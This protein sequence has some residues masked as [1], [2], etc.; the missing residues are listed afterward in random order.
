MRIGIW[1]AYGKTLEPTEGIGVFAHNLARGLVEIDAVERVEL[2]VHAGDEPLVADSVS[3]GGGRVGT[4]SLQ[5][6]RLIERWRWK[7]LRRRHRR[8]SDR[9]AAN[10]RRIQWPSRGRDESRRLAIERAIRGIFAAQRVSEPDAFDAC[11]VWLLPHV[12]VERPFRTASVVVVHDMV[13][14]HFEG[15]VKRSDLA[16]FR[17][18]SCRA[19]EDATLVATMSHTIRDV[20]VVGLLGCDPAKVRVVPPATPV[21]SLETAA[22]P[23]SP[24]VRAATARPFLLYPAA[25]RPY[26]NHATLVAALA[27][28]SRRGRT[29]LGLVFTGGGPMPPEIGSLVSGLGLRGRVH[30]L[31]TVPRGTLSSLYTRAAATIVPSLYEQ[32]SFPI[33]EAIQ[34]GCPAAASD[35]ASLRESLAPLGEAM[36]YFEPRSAESIADAVERILDDREAVRAGQA[37]AFV[38]MRLRSWRDVAREW[39][40]VFEE[41]IAACGGRSGPK[42]A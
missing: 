7:R 32:G 33:L 36:I 10:G 6:L 17:R 29:D 15:V 28:L 34:R 22:E 8:L 37:D 27:E 13:P 11:D 24:A 20:D 1:C 38:V 25:F 14:L 41:A 40:A 21:E 3:G 19:V 18:R 23:P 42:G 35:L 30:P 2:L 39:V 9:L 5:R 4:I 31:G 16:S 26:K 12:A